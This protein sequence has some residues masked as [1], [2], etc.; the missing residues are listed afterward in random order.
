MLM[1]E[2]NSPY[3]SVVLMV[4]YIRKCGTNSSQR[5]HNDAL[6]RGGEGRGGHVMHGRAG[7]ETLAPLYDT[8]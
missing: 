3:I 7:P 8:V 5:P 4:L 6:G 1:S 2:P